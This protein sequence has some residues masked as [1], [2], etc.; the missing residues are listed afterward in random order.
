MAERDAITATV[1]STFDRHANLAPNPMFYRDGIRSVDEL[2][3]SLGDV[4][5]RLKEE[6]KKRAPVSMPIPAGPAKS[7]VTGPSAER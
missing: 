1:R 4:L 3:R 5:T 6:I 2:R 7:V